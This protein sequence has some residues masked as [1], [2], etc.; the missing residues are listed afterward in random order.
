MRVAVA[1]SFKRTNIDRTLPVDKGDSMHGLRPFRTFRNV[2]WIYM[3]MIAGVTLAG[4]KVGSSQSTSAG[5]SSAPTQPVAPPIKSNLWRQNAVALDK[6]VDTVSPSVRAVRD[7]YWNAIFPPV[8]GPGAVGYFTGGIIGT[9]PAVPP[10]EFSPEALRYRWIIGEFESFH[11]YQTSGHGGLYTEMNI[12]VRHVFQGAPAEISEGQ[13]LDLSVRGGAAIDATGR[14]LQFLLTDRAL[15]I[16]PNH[17]Y[18]MQVIPCAKM[19]ACGAGRFYY[20]GRKFDLTD[21]TVR[22]VDTFEVRMWKDG[23][24]KISGTDASTIIPRFAAILTKLTVEAA[25]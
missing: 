13:L 3:A 15:L 4:A 25:K 19:S 16:E 23:L 7:Q 18:L 11:V 9:P 21:G 20:L 2:Q 5:L 6:Q 10:R 14:T 22:P 8:A 24:S 17:L 1:F 12:R